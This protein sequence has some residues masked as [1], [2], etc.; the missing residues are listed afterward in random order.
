MH[1]PLNFN[2]IDCNKCLISMYSSFFNVGILSRQALE[3]VME[4]HI[5]LFLHCK[6]VHNQHNYLHFSKFYNCKLL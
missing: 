2:E 1:L 3:L 4:Q 5:Y 6:L